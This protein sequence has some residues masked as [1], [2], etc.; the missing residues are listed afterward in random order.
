MDVLVP[1]P[2]AL[3]LLGAAL[4]LIVGRRPRQQTIIS[5]VTLT[6]VLVI[7]LLLV[8]Q[9]DSEGI[10]VYQVGAWPTPLAIELVADRLSV[11]LLAISSAVTLCVFF[12]AA[13]QGLR[14]ANRETPLSIFHPT[15]LILVA[16]V[17]NAFLAGDLFNLFVSFEILLAASYVLITLNPGRRRVR[18]G[19]TYVMV[20][21]LSSLL[22]LVAIAL[23]YG[24]TGTLNMAQLA[25]RLN[26][27]PAETALLLQLM[28]LIVFGI[29]A[30]VFPIS[31]WLPDSY[32]T[33]PSPITAVFAGLLTKVGVYAILR[34]Q[35]LL[36][37]NDTVDDLMLWVGL[38]TMLVGILGAIAQEDIKRLLSFTLVS[39]IGFIIFGIGLASTLAYS[40]AVYYIMHHITV[41]TALFLVAGLIERM[42]G[43]TA[44][45]R[46]GGLAKLSPLLAILFMFAA[47]NLA[48]IP[49]FSGFMGK[50]GLLQA[51]VEYGNWL[52]YLLV[53]GATVTT[54]L[55]LYAVV[56][57][58]TNA[59]WRKPPKEL[60]E[61]FSDS[62]RPSAGATDPTATAPVPVSP[63]RT[64]W[65]VRDPKTGVEVEPRT[66]IVTDPLTG[67]LRPRPSRLL[68]RPM[69]IPTVALVGLG[70]ALAVFA[71]PLFEYTDRTARDLINRSVYIDAVN[72]PVD[73]PLG[74]DSITTVEPPTLEEGVRP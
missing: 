19:T 13:G 29:K 8:W 72:P 33:A 56:K 52:A 53:A 44:L 74:T 36:F 73:R 9:V 25:I 58:W 2:V 61:R 15:Y 18:A 41:Q 51:G 14:D 10:I 21:L 16:G 48:G 64:T 31:A 17:S 70:V 67:S 46:M 37:P 4:C 32:P 35:T 40:S 55:T 50:I 23:V 5:A 24:A 39:H 71:G 54:L 45:Q 38:F 27:I 59:F 28:L 3:P 49:P 47:M 1:L 20:S 60:L 26:E 34:T 57:I 65:A 69:L 66:L 42:A 30:A 68:P 62:S 11:L 6:A 22:F 7:S 12:F 43:T 63:A